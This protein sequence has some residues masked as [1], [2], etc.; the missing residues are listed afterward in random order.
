MSVNNEMPNSTTA[1]QSLFALCGQQND[2]I[3]AYRAEVARATEKRTAV[4]R[5][6][7]RERAP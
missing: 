6:I 1:A 7:C 4:A 5:A 2:Q 3:A